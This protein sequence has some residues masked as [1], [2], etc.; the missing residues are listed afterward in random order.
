MS[1]TKSKTPLVVGGAVVAIAAIAVLFVLPAET[2]W[3]PTGIGARLGLTEIAD[4]VNEELERGMARM[5]TQDVLLLS[6]TAPQPEEGVSDVWEYELPPYESIEYKYTIEQG[7]R[8]AFT[9]EGS[10]ILNYDMH[11]HPFDGG[12]EAT[13]SFGVDEAQIQHGVYIAPFTGIHGWY[14]QNRGLE[15]ATVRIEATGGMTLATIF[16]AS[17]PVELPIEGVENSLEG[18]A[19]GHAMQDSEEEAAET[20]E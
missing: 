10:D 4:P 12:V 16:S 1:E 9:W 5:E 19:E 20:A 11:S 2:G 7:E 13:E 3:D 15:P 6:D 17:G 18:A 8:I 14:W